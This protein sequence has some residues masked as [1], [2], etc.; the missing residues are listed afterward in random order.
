[1][2]RSDGIENFKKMIGK[3]FGED[4]LSIAELCF[5]IVENPRRRFEKMGKIFQKYLDKLSKIIELKEDFTQTFKKRM[6]MVL[7]EH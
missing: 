7:S 4:I 2:F 3:Y 6:E 5:F 1:M